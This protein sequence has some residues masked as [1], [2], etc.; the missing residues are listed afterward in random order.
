M[1][2]WGLAIL[3]LAEGLALG[4]MAS[5]AARARVASDARL[6]VE[7]D[8]ALQSA[9]ALARVEHDTL[10]ARLPPD[11]AQRLP[12]PRLDGWIVAVQAARDAADP[13]VE[14]RVEVRR[15][16][17]SL[18]AWVERRGTLILRIG[19]ADTALVMD[20]RPAY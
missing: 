8:L 13:L 14:L 9:I 7:A 6:A 16:G 1:L 19:P 18:G 20:D 11:P 15:D 5:V 17:G 2:A 12:A 3:I 4:L 10:L